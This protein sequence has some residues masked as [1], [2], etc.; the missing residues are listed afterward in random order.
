VQE[1]LQIGSSRDNGGGKG[2]IPRASPA[3]KDPDM[4]RLL[5]SPLTGQGSRVIGQ[6][7]HY[8]EEEQP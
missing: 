3:V 1:L 2:G 5:L 7:N 4:A 8:T 6:V